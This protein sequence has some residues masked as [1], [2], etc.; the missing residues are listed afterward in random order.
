MINI[1]MN[2]LTRLAALPSVPE[3]QQAISYTVVNA[4]SNL[5]S[6]YASYFYPASPGPRY[7]QANAANVAFSGLCISMTMVLMFFLARRN[8]KLEKAGDYNLQHEDMLTGSQ[9]QALT[10]KRQCGTEYVYTLEACR[11]SW[12]AIC[13]TSMLQIFPHLNIIRN[14]MVQILNIKFNR[15]IR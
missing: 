12:Y 2:G 11:L 7:W 3:E 5:A 13:E 14:T 1:G 10:E 6:I 15:Y 9:T 8:K 4:G